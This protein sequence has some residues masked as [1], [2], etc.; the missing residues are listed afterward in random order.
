MV[1]GVSKND[2]EQSANWLPRVFLGQLVSKN[3]KNRLFCVKFSLAAPVQPR[4][5]KFHMNLSYDISKAWYEYHFDRV[6]LWRVIWTGVSRNAENRGFFNPEKSSSPI[7]STGATAKTN[8]MSLKSFY[9]LLAF[10]NELIFYDSPKTR[11]TRIF[12]MWQKRASR[13]RG[14]KTKI[15][16]NRYLQ[17]LSV[18]NDRY[19]CTEYYS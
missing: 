4:N 7:W 13:K 17:H 15:F 16:I 10:Q 9:S 2:K 8:E 18:S 14:E 3:T 12:Y 1:I 19:W 11:F 5:P 6:I